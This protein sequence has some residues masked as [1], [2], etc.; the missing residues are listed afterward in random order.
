MDIEN[1]E[2][3]LTFI[4]KEKK[5]FNNFNYT[6]TLDLFFRIFIKNIIEMKKN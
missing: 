1:S 6:K 3:L 2:N 4:N 5:Q